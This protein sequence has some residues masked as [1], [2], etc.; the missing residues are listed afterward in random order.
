MYKPASLIIDNNKLKL[1]EELDKILREQKKLPRSSLNI[2]RG[3]L[4]DGLL[5]SKI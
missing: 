1:F 3:V 2:A 4:T 5:K